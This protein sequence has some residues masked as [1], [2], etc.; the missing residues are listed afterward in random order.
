MV[1]QGKSVFV[2]EYDVYNRDVLKIKYFYQDDRYLKDSG[3][4]SL[5]E[6][7]SAAGHLGYAAENPLSSARMDVA[8]ML[9]RR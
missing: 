4:Y 6:N 3:T 5:S 2:L 1:L 9:G 7:Q 8:R